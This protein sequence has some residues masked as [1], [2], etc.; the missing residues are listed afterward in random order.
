M[1]N[2]KIKKSL[3]SIAAISAFLIY[4]KK[5]SIF[6]KNQKY[7]YNI[8]ET[9]GVPIKE[10][11]NKLTP[12]TT[13]NIEGVISVLSEL[14]SNYTADTTK[15]KYDKIAKEIVKYTKY[16]D[17]RALTI[18]KTLE[19]K[20]VYKIIPHKELSSK[21][22]KFINSISKLE[23]YAKKAKKP[24]T[25]NLVDV[26]KYEMLVAISKEFDKTKKVKAKP[27]KTITKKK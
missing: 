4:K 21:V 18:H 22:E 3:L 23:S 10:L 12:K 17:E 20:F 14:I 1:K 26:I 11:K 13:E 7:H 27:K 16:I 8:S 24:K 9:T 5:D 19:E 25:K 6:K 2:K 15:I